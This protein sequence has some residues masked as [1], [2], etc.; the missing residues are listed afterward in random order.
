MLSVR[1]AFA[2]AS[3]RD[4][5]SVIHITSF[6][7]GTTSTCLPEAARRVVHTDRN[8]TGSAP[9]TVTVR[10]LAVKG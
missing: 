2:G 8:W 10:K 9:R 6:A 1:K 4:E 5:S 7:S 3:G